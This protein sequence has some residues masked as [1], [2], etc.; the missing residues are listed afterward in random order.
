[1]MTNRLPIYVLTTAV[2]A[3]GGNSRPDAPSDAMSPVRV[4][5]DHT[6]A[7]AAGVQGA[8]GA[9][10]ATPPSLLGLEIVG[11]EPGATFLVAGITFGGDT[12]LFVHTASGRDPISRVDANTLLEHGNMQSGEPNAV[13]TFQ[14]PVLVYRDTPS[15]AVLV[16]Q[17]AD[18]TLFPPDGQQ[19]REPPICSGRA[20]LIDA[21]AAA[22]E[23]TGR[24]M[25]TAPTDQASHLD[26][27]T[28]GGAAGPPRQLR[29]FHR[30]ARIFEKR[31]GTEVA[32]SPSALAGRPL[33]VRHTETV[34]FIDRLVAV[35]AEIEAL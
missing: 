35:A 17:A 19:L 12:P 14:G 23:D 21:S 16:A 31:S 15:G 20:G 4:L 13:V 34:F 18:V 22:I 24:I 7:C 26:I 11:P 33:R 28:D 1:M 32:I 5:A 10:Y 2:A 30:D 25:G 9:K 3:C 27:D 29:V 6:P 8:V